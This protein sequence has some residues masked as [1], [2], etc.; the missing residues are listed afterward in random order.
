MTMKRRD[1][2]RRLVLLTW[3]D[4]L[5]VVCGNGF[6]TLACVTYEHL[7]PKS[8]G[9]T[10]ACLQ[11]LGVSHYSCNRLRA[12]GSLLEGARAVSKMRNRIGEEQF[13]QWLA[14]KV[15]DR[16]V[17]PEVLYPLTDFPVHKYLKK[18]QVTDWYRMMWAGDVVERTVQ[19]LLAV[20]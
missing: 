2:T 18:S 10:K 1:I 5:C 4:G 19:S 9:G 17:P 20:G 12:A 16:E 13:R 7:R 11:K 6:D 8:M 15:P 14:K 3:W